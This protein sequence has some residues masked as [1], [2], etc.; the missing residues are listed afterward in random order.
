MGVLQAAYARLRALARRD[1]STAAGP[2]ASAGARPAPLRHL[3]LRRPL[4]FF[5]LET[6][7]PNPEVDRII[8]IALVKVHPGGGRQTLTLRVNPGVA[9]APESSAVH[10]ITDGDVA[11]A[12]LFPGV[13]ADVLAFIGDADLAGFNV[14]RFDLPILQRELDLAGLH[15]DLTARAVLDVQTIYHRREPRDLSAAYRYYVGKELRNAHAALAD[16]E[17]C[18]EILDAQLRVYTDLPRTPPEL[19]ERFVPAPRNTSSA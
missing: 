15:L 8:E 2:T 12:P 14:H 9:I 10:R 19:H 1:K 17:A 16:V 6:T 11:S 5:D 3:T 7:G 13:A 4:V 18:V